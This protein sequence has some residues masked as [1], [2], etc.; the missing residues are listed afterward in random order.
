MKRAQ[1]VTKR[2]CD[3]V[4]PR[5]TA[6]LLTVPVSLL[7]CTDE[8]IVVLKPPVL[9]AGLS[10][11][12]RPLQCFAFLDTARVVR[13][14][15]IKAATAVAASFVQT[16]SACWILTRRRRRRRR[17]VVRHGYCL[18]KMQ[19]IAFRARYYS[20]STSTRVHLNVRYYSTRV[21]REATR[22]EY[23]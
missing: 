16:G 2:T 1:A 20:S 4:T 5:D 11:R 12:F 19:G 13:I 23:R 7:V 22:T 3:R 14:G 9:L 10:R 8:S 15:A 21:D 17:A 18:R 6:L